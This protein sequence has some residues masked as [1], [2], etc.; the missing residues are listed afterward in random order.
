MS[1]KLVL[2]TAQL[3]LGNY[4]ITSDKEKMSKKK[5]SI[6]LILPGKKELNIL[7]QPQVIKMNK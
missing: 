6:Y 3:Y 7:I 4:G 1:K 2:G 5:Y